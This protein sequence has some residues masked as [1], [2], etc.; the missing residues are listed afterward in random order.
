MTEQEQIE[1]AGQRAERAESAARRAE[2]QIEVLKM[3]ADDLERNDLARKESAAAYAVEAMVRAGKVKS[4]D[5]LAKETYKA[6]FIHDPS[7][8]D[9]LFLK[10]ANRKRI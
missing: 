8:I 6:Q 9:L 2:I 7:L 10:P 5:V 1:R 4:S 3:K